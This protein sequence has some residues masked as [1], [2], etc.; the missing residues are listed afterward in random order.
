MHELVRQFFETF[1]NTRELIQWGGTLLVCTI[2]FVETG[3][4][5]GFFLPGDSLLVTSG[6]FAAA[7]RLSLGW[8]LVLVPLCAIA[9]D[10]IGYWIGRRAGSSLLQRPDSRWVKRRYFEQAHTFYERHGASAIILARF[11][12][13]ARTFC[14]AVAGI[15]QMSYR[16]FLRYDV[17]GGLLWGISLQL[18]GYFLGA[19]VPHIEERIHWV[20]AAVVILSVLPGLFHLRRARRRSSA[21]TA[22]MLDSDPLP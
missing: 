5:A 21:P 11:V 15:A 16:K 13:I 10:Q 12:P 3:L 17:F 2:V 22:E 18:A 6:V 14:P 4:L 7:G 20:V 9:G 1:Y 8:L 19:A